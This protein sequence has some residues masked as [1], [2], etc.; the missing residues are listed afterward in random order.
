MFAAA[1]ASMIFFWGGMY[2]YWKRVD[3]FLF[4]VLHFCR[5]SFAATIDNNLSTI[6]RMIWIV[7]ICLYFCPFPP[8]PPLPRLAA[9]AYAPQFLYDVHRCTPYI[10]HRSGSPKS[11]ADAKLNPIL[12]F[13]EHHSHLSTCVQA[14]GGALETARTNLGPQD[15]EKPPGIGQGSQCQL[16]RC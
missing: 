7:T 15:S 5:I 11:G 8:L 3:L 1:M 13:A 9:P 16:P 6:M 12:L 10:V 2:M 4:F 14:V